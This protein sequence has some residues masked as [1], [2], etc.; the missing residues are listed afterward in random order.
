MFSRGELLTSGTSI[1]WIDRDRS[2]QYY[3]LALRG[4]VV[5]NLEMVIVKVLAHCWV[6][7]DRVLGLSPVWGVGLVDLSSGLL[8]PILTCLCAPVLGCGVGR[9]A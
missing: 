4:G 6:L 5:W 7:R 8:G 9:V 1:S 2:R 3:Q